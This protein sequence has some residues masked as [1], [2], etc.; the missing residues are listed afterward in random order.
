MDKNTEELTSLIEAKRIL[1]KKKTELL[2]G[3]S[4]YDKMA[5][6]MEQL[7]GDDFPE[8]LKIQINGFKK[9]SNH[10]SETFDEMLAEMDAE[11]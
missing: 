3:L 7:G 11:F 5:S 2:S 6:L 1:L 10:T 9:I 4:I 8:T